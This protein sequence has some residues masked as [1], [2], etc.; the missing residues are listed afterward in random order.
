MA[1]RRG[2]GKAEGH[3]LYVRWWLQSPVLDAETLLHFGQTKAWAEDGC[4]LCLPPASFLCGF[5]PLCLELTHPRLTPLEM[6][7]HLGNDPLCFT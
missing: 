2:V 7:K 1:R 3:L 6:R 5:M 4:S